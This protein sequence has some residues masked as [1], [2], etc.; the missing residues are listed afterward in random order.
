MV[1]L[2]RCIG[3]VTQSDTEIRARFDDPLIVKANS[4][5][6]LLNCKVQFPNI[7]AEGQITIITGVNDTLT[8]DGTE[9]TIPAGVYGVGSA[10]GLDGTLE[11]LIAL[12]CGTLGSATVGVDYRVD[13]GSNLTNQFELT[14]TASS[15]ALAKWDDWL[16]IEGTPDLTTDGVYKSDL[17]YPDAEQV[18]SQY[19]VPNASFQFQATVSAVSPNVLNGPDDNGWSFGVFGGL[20]EQYEIG[21]FDSG[22]DHVYFYRD[23]NNDPNGY[24][25]LSPALTSA[26]GD[27]LT[28]SRSSDTVTFSVKRGGA[29]VRTATTTLD[30]EDIFGVYDDSPSPFAFIKNLDPLLELSDVKLTLTESGVE[31]TLRTIPTNLRLELGSQSLAHYLGFAGLGPFTNI[32]DPAVIKSPTP[33]NPD[34]QTAGVLVTI[35]PLVLDSYDGDTRGTTGK[36]GRDSI[37]AVL[38]STEN[39]GRNINLDVNFP[40]ALDVKNAR[41]FNVNQLS[42]RFKDQSN[43]GILQFAKN[44]VVTLVIYGPDESP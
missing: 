24:N 14:K 11:A 5:V 16:A 31:S 29:V 6:A 30:F 10:A 18:I 8:V 23:M 28:I 25:V 36:K 33:I 27:I 41:D 37:L 13:I 39:F 44:A 42:I 19:R 43:G 21:V 2:L 38:N 3:D 17:T 34:F 15:L 22:A 26:V 32:G 35:D 9:V 40:V 20:T 4:K 12:D 1:K 7:I